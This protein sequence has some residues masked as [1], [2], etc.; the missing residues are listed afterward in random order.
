M[1]TAETTGLKSALCCHG[2]RNSRSKAQ[3]I[4]WLNKAGCRYL[5]EENSSH[6]KG[7]PVL[8]AIKDD[9]DWCI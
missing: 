6:A 5:V 2:M 4:L 3:T 1:L 9:I 8:E 7:V